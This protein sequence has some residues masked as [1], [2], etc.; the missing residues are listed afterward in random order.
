VDH[1]F[2]LGSP[3]LYREWGYVALSRGRQTNRLYLAT[4][5]QSDDLHHHAP[6]PAIDEAAALSSRL[7]RSRAQQSVSEAPTDVASRWRQAHT[8]LHAPDITRQQALTGRRAQL[9]HQRQADAEQLARVRRRL[10]HASTG[11]GR[12]RNR[13]LRTRLQAEHD[14]RVQGLT[15]LDEQLHQLDTELAALPS[16]QQIAHLQAQHRQLTSQLRWTASRAVAGYRHTPPAHLTATLGPPPPDPRGRARWDQ[17]ALTI[18][19]HR[20]RWNITDPHR[21]LGDTPTDPLQVDE[22][23]AVARTIERHHHQLTRETRRE[24]S[25]ARGL[26][27]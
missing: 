22:H 2:V 8:R 5:D 26:S 18:E 1:T 12:L 11:L 9:A 17:A 10:D 23:R 21:A 24:H 16:P 13:E 4:V 6:E 14:L 25:H 15:R 27:R 7:Q 20:L 3:E 19:E